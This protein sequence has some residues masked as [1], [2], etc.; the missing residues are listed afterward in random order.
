MRYRFGVVVAALVV[1]CGST[2]TLNGDAGSDAAS[3]GSKKD[4]SN[5][6]GLN[7]GDTGADTAKPSGC[8]EVDTTSF[9]PT[10]KPTYQTPT[11]FGQN[12]CT[13]TQMYDYLASCAWSG[14]SD[15]SACATKLNQPSSLDCFTCLAPG[16]STAG[17]F[18]TPKD[19]CGEQPSFN[20]GGCLENALGSSCASAWMDAN[21]CAELACSECNF[22]GGGE[23]IPDYMHPCIAA[24]GNS[25][26]DN[27]RT[28]AACALGSTSPTVKAC[29]AM[30]QP[31]GNNDYYAFAGLFCGAGPGPSDA[32]TD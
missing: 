28:A 19:A 27:L 17:P 26:C 1:A 3:D 5:D 23:D 13:Q 12:R 9:T 4:A 16:T 30:V 22:C 21:Q 15:P 8:G 2:S 18:R 32:G 14:A 6:T 25:G 31:T 24:G 20:I 7:F 10:W 29:L 11:A